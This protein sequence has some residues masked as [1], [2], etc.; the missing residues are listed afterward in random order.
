MNQTPKQGKKYG[1]VVTKGNFQQ[2]QQYCTQKKKMSNTLIKDL[3]YH[4]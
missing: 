1:T 2:I 3:D 4:C